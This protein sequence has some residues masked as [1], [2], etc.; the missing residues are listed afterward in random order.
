MKKLKPFGMIFILEILGV[1]FYSFIWT[2][3]FMHLVRETLVA[4]EILT[5][6]QELLIF[7]S[8]VL[9][10]GVFM[11]RWIY[12]TLGKMSIYSQTLYVTPQEDN[13]LIVLFHTIGI[14]TILT[15]F[16]DMIT[17]CYAFFTLQ[18]ISTQPYFSDI[19]FW[20][21]TYYYILEVPMYVVFIIFLL[22]TPVFFY[23]HSA[24]VSG[25]D[26]SFD[27]ER[28]ALLQSLRSNSYKY[29]NWLLKLFEVLGIFGVLFYAFIWMK[30]FIHIVGGIILVC[31]TNFI[32]ELLI[33]IVIIFATSTFVFLGLSLYHW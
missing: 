30:L 11:Y 33:V 19:I 22:K 20:K 27:L 8:V 23:L 16:I 14:F 17:R 15:L 10:S 5:F 18:H 21:N 1:L 28:Y 24:F 13:I 29:T 6:Y 9:A 4:I 7:L 31:N 26:L 32:Q 3:T 25:L 2:K 12:Y